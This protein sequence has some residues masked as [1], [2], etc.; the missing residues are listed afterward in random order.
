M[1]AVIALTDME[2]LEVAASVDLHLTVITFQITIKH[3]L[4]IFMS[5]TAAASAQSFGGGFGGPFGGFS[6]SAA[7]AQA[8][9]S[10]FGFGR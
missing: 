9:S 6:G 2:D 1:E 4:L 5:S 3:I 8:G 7:N 10:S